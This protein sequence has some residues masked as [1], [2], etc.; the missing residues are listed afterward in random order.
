MKIYLRIFIALILVSLVNIE[1]S[2]TSIDS[3]YYSAIMGSL[4][5]LL[6]VVI[7]GS[8]GQIFIK[9]DLT[10]YKF[11]NGILVGTIIYEFMQINIDGRVFD[12]LDL[13]FSILGWLL[14]RL[15]YQ[16]DNYNIYNKV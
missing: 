7:L 15:L 10:F 2:A 1:Q 5:N 14:I 13:L 6:S 11:I 16:R 4:P 12:W 8:L 9:S 3:V